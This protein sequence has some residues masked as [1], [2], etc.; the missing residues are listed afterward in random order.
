LE[1]LAAAGAFEPLLRNRRRVYEGVEM[2]LRHASAATNERD[3]NQASLFGGPA[4]SHAEDLPLPAVEEWPIMDRLRREFEAVGFYLSAHPLDAYGKG[5]DRLGV[6]SSRDLLSAVAPGEGKRLNMAGTVIG[7]QERTSARGNRFAFVQLSD[8][9]G[10]YETTVFSELLATAR[11][12]LDSG[13]PVLVTVD[14]RREDD[15]IKLLAQ[16]FEPLDQAAAR[17]AAGLVVY[18]RDAAV[19]PNLASVIERQDPGRGRVSLILDADT[20]EVEVLLKK[21]YRISAATRA[22]I[23]SIPGIVDVRDL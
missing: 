8:A 1:S 16:A 18:L 7:R 9:G 13:E 15:Q 5:L 17:A 14:A 6:L 2:L 4:E 23:K 10:V 21:T 12:L 11:E 20:R 3:S 22:A 19:L